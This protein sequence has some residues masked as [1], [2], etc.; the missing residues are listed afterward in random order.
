MRSRKQLC[1]AN[2]EEHAAAM[3]EQ[4]EEQ[5]T[6]ADERAGYQETVAGITRH[7]AC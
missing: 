7:T 3:L 2:N 5:D 1:S 6:A 4:H